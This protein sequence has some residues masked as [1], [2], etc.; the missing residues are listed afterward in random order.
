MAVPAPKSNELHKDRQAIFDAYAASFQLDLVACKRLERQLSELVTL[1]EFEVRVRLEFGLLHAIRRNMSEARKH[2]ARA[3]QLGADQDLLK[4]NYAHAAVLNGEVLEAAH[5]VASLPL[6]GNPDWLRSIRTIAVQCG[7]FGKALEA[8]EALRKLNAI[9]FESN[10]EYSHQST[11]EVIC[12]AELLDDRGLSDLDVAQRVH[13]AA[14]VI[15]KRVPKS[16]LL[17]YGYSCTKEAG[18]LYEF[19]LRLP[20]DELVGLDWEISEALVEAFDDPLTGIV[21]FSTRPF[22]ESLCSVA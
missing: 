11:Q 4:L 22:S 17:V 10:A 19:P 16:A 3:G 5:Y 6:K 18:I 1:P 13:V 14:Q 7:M 15:A 2:L 8:I 12:G 21:G 9:P 20:I